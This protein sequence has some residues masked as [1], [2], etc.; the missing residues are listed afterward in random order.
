MF[1]DK[2]NI[3][4]LVAYIYMLTNNEEIPVSKIE[5]LAKASS[6][7]INL[8][9]VRKHVCQMPGDRPR[10]MLML[11]P[12]GWALAFANAPPPGLTT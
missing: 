8:S 6:F 1:C 3:V 4:H 7:P 12:R 2:Q 10:E 9:V 5:T 11:S